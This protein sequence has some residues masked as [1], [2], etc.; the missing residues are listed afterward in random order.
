MCWPLIHSSP[1]R[2]VCVCVLSQNLKRSC[3]D[4]NWEVAPQKKKSFEVLTAVSKIMFI[5]DV[6]SCSLVGQ[7][8]HF[9]FCFHICYHEDAG[10]RFLWYMIIYLPKYVLSHSRDPQAWY[11]SLTKWSTGT[12]GR[13]SGVVNQGCGC[14][15]TGGDMANDILNIRGLPNLTICIR[16]AKVKVGLRL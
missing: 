5:W 10:N 11:T 6:M 9:S 15:G 4:L 7:Y 12:G 14:Y 16:G 3:L 2:C 13:F 1:T 8:Q